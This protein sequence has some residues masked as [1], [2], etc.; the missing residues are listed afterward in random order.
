MRQ[1]IYDNENFSKQYDTMRKEEGGINANDLIEIPNFRKIMPQVVGKSIL[2]LG[3]GYGESDVY[4]KGL[5]ASFVLGT[6]ISKHMIEIA[7]K[8]NS[9]EGV[10]YKLLAMEDLDTIEE[11]FD[12]VMSSLALHYVADFGMI[13]KSVY[14]K[15]NNGGYFVFSIEH[16]MKLAP[17]LNGEVEK[18]HLEINGKYFQLISDYNREGERKRLWNGEYVI[19]YHR[20]MSSIINTLIKAGFVIEEILEPIPSEEALNKRPKY[21]NQFDSPFFLFVRARKV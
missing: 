14:D 11:R 15:L 3:C 8:E 17:I 21:K 12:I 9:V 16:P 6:D 5:G 13:V 7:K 1:N 2:D 4:F 19:K 10:E 18:S 20:S